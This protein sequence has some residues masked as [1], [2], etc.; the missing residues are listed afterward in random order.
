MTNVRA[1]KII[2][3][4]AIKAACKDCDLR[5]LCLP[6][7]LDGTDVEALDKLIKRRRVLKKGEHLYRLGD[8]LRALYAVRSGTFKSTGLMEDGRS[9]VTGFYLPGE[10]LGMDAINADKHPCNAEALEAAEVCEI[11]FVALEELA[12]QVPGLQHQLLRLMSREIVRDEHTLMMLGR[13]TADERLASCLVSFGK[14]S[15][16]LGGDGREFML[17]MSRQDIGDYLGLALETV[18]RLFTRFREDGLIEVDGRHLRVRD[19]ARLHALAAGTA[20]LANESS[21]RA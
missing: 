11:P 12:Q 16:R 15:A 10:L 8:P 19:H 7:G 18:S 5:E 2:N 14:R 4:T 3:I 9:H 6:L 21:Q 13:M 1:A 20:T 17:S